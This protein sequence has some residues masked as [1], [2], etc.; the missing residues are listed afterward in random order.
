MKKYNILTINPGSTATKYCLF[1]GGQKT[2]Q[3]IFKRAHPKILSQKE[4]DFL[5]N[6]QY[7]AVS[8]RVVH[9]GEIQKSVILDDDIYKIIEEFTDFAPI[10]N[11]ASLATIDH[12]DQFVPKV[13]VPDTFFHADLPK[14]EVIYP[15]PKRYAE[16]GVRRFGFH[17]LALKSVLKQLKEQNKE[18]EKII[19]AHLGGGSSVTAIKNGKSFATSMGA[20]PL[21]GVMM[22]TRSGNVDPA[23]PYLLSKKDFLSPDEIYSLLNEHSGFKALTDMTDTKFIFDKAK[24]GKEPYKLAVDIFM[25]SVKK[26]IFAYAGLMQ[27]VDL[28]V[29]SGG[30]GEGNSWFRK[31]ILKDLGFVGIDKEKVFI[32]KVDES[33]ILFE[34]AEKL[35]N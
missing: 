29:F 3:A 14:E 35:L 31:E 20:T 17:S 7:D 2:Q 12:I 13:A 9:M 23:L 22:I 34:E 28:L 18:F 8:I 5:K 19:V 32:C 16:Q 15:I 10:H 33:E 30:I 6:T 25:R 26:Y 4:V 27:G 24:E 21:E 11:T 1:E